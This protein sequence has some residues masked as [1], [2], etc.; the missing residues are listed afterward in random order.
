MNIPVAAIFAF[1]ALVVLLIVVGIV[2]AIKRHKE[3]D[4]LK[5]HG[6]HVQAAV[7]EITSEQVAVQVPRQVQK[8]RYNPVSRRPESTFQTEYQTHFQTRYHIIARYSESPT[9]QEYVFR[10]EALLSVPKQH[11]KGSMVL[12]HYDPANPSLYYMDLD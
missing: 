7:S 6:K 11:M 8:T 2:A 5:E 10:S 4:R 3:I 12:V 9:T 1:A